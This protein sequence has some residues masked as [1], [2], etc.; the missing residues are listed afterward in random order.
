MDPLPPLSLHGETPRSGSPHPEQQH[1]VLLSA[2]Q[3]AHKSH[4]DG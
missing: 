4:S 1:A 3:M 2:T